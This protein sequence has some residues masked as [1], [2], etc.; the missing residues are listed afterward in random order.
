MKNNKE[1]RKEVNGIGEEESNLAL[2][3]QR[4]KDGE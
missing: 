1:W 4:E 2:R 3:E